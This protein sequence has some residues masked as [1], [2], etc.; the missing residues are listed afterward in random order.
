MWLLLCIIFQLSIYHL[1]NDKGV[2]LK[3]CGKKMTVEA[4]KK[5]SETEKVFH[6]EKMEM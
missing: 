1:K 3:K 2:Y 6:I 4:M 5:W